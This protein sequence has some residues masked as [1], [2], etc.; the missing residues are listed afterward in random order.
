MADKTQEIIVLN[1]KDLTKSN[2]IV[3]KQDIRA[4]LTKDQIVRRLNQMPGGKHKAICQ[5]L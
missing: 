1:D 3:N 2:V 5:T 4:Y